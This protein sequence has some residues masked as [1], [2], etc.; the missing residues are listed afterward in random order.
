MMSL[1]KYVSGD[2]GWTVT[3]EAQLRARTQV[4]GQKQKTEMWRGLGAAGWLHPA[5]V[6][7][8]NTAFSPHQGDFASIQ[9][10][11]HYVLL[12]FRGT[13]LT[14]SIISCRT[15]MLRHVVSAV[16]TSKPQQDFIDWNIHFTLP[17]IFITA[18]ICMKYVLRSLGQK[19][20]SC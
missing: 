4:S 19:Y 9:V 1:H 17:L 18:I 13:E 6:F 7:V 11:C 16:C 12:A 2:R 20:S 5:T 10:V 8:Y 14:E 3:W 15:Y